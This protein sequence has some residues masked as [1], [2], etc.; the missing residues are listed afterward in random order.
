[1][2]MWCVSWE[3]IDL[4]S[5]WYGMPVLINNYYFF[6]LLQSI[7]CKQPDHWWTCRWHF[8]SPTLEVSESRQVAHTQNISGVYLDW[9]MI[10]VTSVRAMGKH[11]LYFLSRWSI[12]NTFRVR[13]VFDNYDGQW[14]L[15]NVCGWFWEPLCRDRL[16]C[17]WNRR[18][19]VKKI[20]GID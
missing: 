2:K 18:S 10:V 5:S 4:I 11:P 12:S 15:G 14:W 8:Q 1:M 16:E 17:K 13:E 9:R 20:K 19:A 6:S 3:I 7:S